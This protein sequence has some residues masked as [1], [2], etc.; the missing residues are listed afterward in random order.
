MDT[1]D[2]MDTMDNVIIGTQKSIADLL[3]TY[4]INN[5]EDNYKKLWLSLRDKRR[6][7]GNLDVDSIFILTLIDIYRKLEYIQEIIDSTKE[8][9]SK[10][11]YLELTKTNME[12]YIDYENSENPCN[13]NFFN[14]LKQISNTLNT[15]ASQLSKIENL[16]IY[17]ENS[18]FFVGLNDNLGKL[19]ILQP[20]QDELRSR[21]FNSVNIYKRQ[22]TGAGHKK[23]TKY[24]PKSKPKPKPKAKPVPKAKHD[25]MNMKDIKD[26][27]KTNQIKLSKVVNEKRVRFTKKELLTKLKRKKL[28]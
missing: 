13:I 24:K 8:C 27:C 18:K 10:I 11:P 14:R 25:D 9:N 21:Y 15:I 2:T 7:T 23:P 20:N 16:D 3:D 12:K 19:R 4:N 1:M 22:Q 28:I 17:K 5:N 26:L 6:T